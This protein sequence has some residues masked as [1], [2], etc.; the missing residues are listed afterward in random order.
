MEE[1]LPGVVHIT[2]WL[3]R[4][5]GGIPPV[6]WS[7]ARECR[8]MG[9]DCWVAGLSDENVKSDC[10]GYNVPF[11]TGVIIGPRAWGFSPGLGNQVRK[12]IKPGGIIHSH[13]LWMHPG[14]VARSCARKA[15][16]PLVISPHGMLEPW[17]LNRSRWK[18]RLAAWLFEDANLQT[19]NCLHALCTQEAENLRRIGL[20]NPIAVIPNGVDIDA[21][22]TPTK[23]E[24]WLERYPSIKGRKRLLFLS[25]IH[26]K[27]GLVNLLHAWKEVA[28][29]FQDWCLIIAGPDEAGHER[30]LK[31][32]S[33]SLEISGRVSFPGP[34]Y[35]EDKKALLSA[36]D[37]FILPSFSEGISMAVLEAAASALPVML[38]RQCNFPELAGAGAAIEVSS[39]AVEIKAGLR[40]LLSLSD[41]QRKAMGQ[42]GRR[43]MGEAYTWDNVARQ[44]LRLYQWLAG[45][46]SRPDFVS[47]D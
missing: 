21:L 9:I 14:V 41:V 5:G 17:A 7:L 10:P 45:T 28:P 42:R 16:C 4:Q 2:S 32:L 35:G 20:R 22:P 8:R 3:S 34:V 24:Y 30:Q 25:R 46:G 6:V 47:V 31:S 38:T 27:K 40:Q 13:G 44:M 11:V 39:D 29:A 1:I 12:R 43:L 18:K 36:A 33:A 15:G 19:A 23:A 37:A 26:P